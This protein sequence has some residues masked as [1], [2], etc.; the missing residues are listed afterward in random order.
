MVL[1]EPC[2]HSLRLQAAHS[3]RLWLQVAM[4]L[5]LIVHG[6]GDVLQP[7]ASLQLLLRQLTE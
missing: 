5:L 7:V 4:L 6:V 1:N 3:A 2:C